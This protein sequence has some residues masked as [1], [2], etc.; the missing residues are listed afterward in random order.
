METEDEDFLNIMRPGYQNLNMA[1]ITSN[2]KYVNF[3]GFGGIRQGFNNPSNLTRPSYSDPA[4]LLLPGVQA[5]HSS[6]A[7]S[8]GMIGV[9]QT[10]P[11]TPNSGPFGNGYQVPMLGDEDAY[12][13]DE[14]DYPML[15]PSVIGDSRKPSMADETS[16]CLCPGEGFLQGRSSNSPPYHT[17]Y[18]P[19]KTKLPYQPQRL[20]SIQ[21][22]ISP[23]P[24]HFTNP[25]LT[26]SQGMNY[27]H[28]SHPN[29]NPGP[30][31]PPLSPNTTPSTTTPTPVPQ[32]PCSGVSESTIRAGGGSEEIY[33]LLLRLYHTCLDASSL[34]IASM[35][36][37]ASS[38]RRINRSNRNSSY[39]YHPYPPPP[40]AQSRTGGRHE[41]KG[42]GRDRQ[43]ATGIGSKRDMGI[44]RRREGRERT[45]MDN[46]ST[47]STHLWRKARSDIMAPHR[48]E[49]EAVRSMRNLYI[50]GEKV[51]RGMEGEGFLNE[52]GQM[53][54]GAGEAA[55]RICGWLGD[56]QARGFCM[57]V[58]GTLK[59]LEREGRKGGGV[60]GS[61]TE[62]EDG[63]L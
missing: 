25:G 31:T 56:E 58:L 13:E 17:P 33:H 20:P 12:G 59:Q 15:D 53:G 7:S 14:D 8:P 10:N 46:I 50:W 40:Q 43:T 6:R 62:S 38:H 11:T 28:I 36:S 24:S 39:R 49:A 1:S 19:P 51:V 27:I 16:F 35:T 3:G 41:A 45:L 47:I 2:A 42:K 30:D 57:G 55:L 61:V 44:G 32:S 21:S 48:A 34:Y 23:S 4:T 54:V 60:F 18:P 63:I 22:Q 9:E 26:Q 52:E 29:L 5:P 37:S